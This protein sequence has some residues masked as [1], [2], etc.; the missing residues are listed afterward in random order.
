MNCEKCG[1]P[2][3]GSGPLCSACQALET[4]PQNLNTTD[5]TT[6]VPANPP[7]DAPEPSVETPAE[8]ALP[9]TEPSVESP[10]PQTS[11]GSE[12]TSEAQ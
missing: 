11:D 7:A 8:P 10:E 1:T 9:S 3:E 4:P 6:D 12:P 5:P 2:L